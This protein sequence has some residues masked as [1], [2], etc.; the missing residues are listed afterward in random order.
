M[1]A[2]T[3]WPPPIS[4]YSCLPGLCCKVHQ[5]WNQASRWN[6]HSEPRWAAALCF[7]QMLRIKTSLQVGFWGLTFQPQTIMFLSFP[8]WSSSDW[9]HLPCEHVR[10]KDGNGRAGVSFPVRLSFYFFLLATVTGGIRWS[11][12]AMIALIRL[13]SDTYRS[14]STTSQN[15]IRIMNRQNMAW[16][17]LASLK[18]TVFPYTPTNKQ[19]VV[20]LLRW[21]PGHHWH[22]RFADGRAGQWHQQHAWAGVSTKQFGEVSHIS[23]TST[24]SQPR[25]NRNSKLWRQLSVK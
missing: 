11:L 24:V 17:L 5:E 8:T 16:S 23:A 9:G 3:P 19:T 18:S 12:S 21:L 15:Y 10:K 13:T 6:P 4:V 25:V 1:N 20:L 2:I 7:H 22:W 14:K